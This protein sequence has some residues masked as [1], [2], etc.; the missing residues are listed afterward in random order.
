MFSILAKCGRSGIHYF[1]S[2]SFLV[3]MSNQC[4]QSVTRTPEWQMYVCALKL[5]LL[6]AESLPVFACLMISRHPAVKFHLSSILFQY[7]SKIW[8][9]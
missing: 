2:F 9:V 8:L 5:G 3:G 4:C 6:S 7:G 1:V